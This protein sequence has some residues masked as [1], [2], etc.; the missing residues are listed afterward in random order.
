MATRL[1]IVEEFSQRAAERVEKTADIVPAPQAP[2]FQQGPHQTT[3]LMGFDPAPTRKQHAGWTAQRQRRFIEH[4]AVSGNVGEAAAAAGVSS[5]SAYRLR[6]KPGAESF[7]RAWV[8]ALS[9]CS[10]RLA[11]IGLD[12]AMN[13]RVERFYKDGELVMER[14]IPS[15]HLLTWF[16]S[17]LDPAQFGTPAAKAHAATTSDPREAARTDLPALT[18]SFT[19]IDPQDCECEPIDFLDPRLGETGSGDPIGDDERG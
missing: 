16:L 19:D 11:A 10:T 2:E 7:A 4:L 13:G 14:R 6:D 5:R 18:Q 17:R 15:D 1:K 8:A 3:T 12:R 9:L